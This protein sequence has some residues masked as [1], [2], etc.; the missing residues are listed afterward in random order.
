MKNMCEEMEDM[1]R[2]LARKHDNDLITLK[3]NEESER[4]E[5]ERNIKETFD[6]QWKQREEDL[7]VKFCKERD[8][9]IDRVIEKL[10]RLKFAKEDISFQSNAF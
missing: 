5:F 1:R 10:G 7:R 9:E 3:T 8:L 6:R 4:K 2:A